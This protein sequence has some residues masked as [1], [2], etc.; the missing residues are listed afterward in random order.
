M[1]IINTRT[2]FAYFQTY[3][4]NLNSTILRYFQ[5]KIGIDNA[6]NI[7]GIILNVYSDSGNSPND[8]M[9]GVVPEFVDNTYN[10]KNWHIIMNLAKTNLPANTA[11]RSK[12]QINFV[13]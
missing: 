11:V 8:N 9:I 6:G 12:F 2:L 5:Y 4:Y 3:R 7:Q 1:V 10:C 13:S